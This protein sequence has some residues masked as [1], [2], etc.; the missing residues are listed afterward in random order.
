MLPKKRILVGAVGATVAL[1]LQTPVSAFIAK[2][3][4]RPTVSPASGQRPPSYLAEAFSDASQ[5][6]LGSDRW[7]GWRS[8]AGSALAGDSE[9]SA[10]TAAPV[11]ST[12]GDVDLA[13]LDSA[14]AASGRNSFASAAGAGGEGVAH[15]SYIGGS[16][17]GAGGA[18][19]VGGVG[20]GGG[21]GGSALSRDALAAQLLGSNTG[22]NL[23]TGA[24]LGPHAG[25]RTGVFHGVPG[26][27][28]ILDPANG[29]SVGS[30]NVESPEPG[31]L[32]FLGAGLAG[33]A[34]RRSRRRRSSGGDSALR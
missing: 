3:R 12:F 33:L 13:Y 20:G 19:G 30:A 21:G 25:Y 31:T 34:A 5:R 32:L 28:V 2:A 26:P 22:G 27:A 10:G 4:T 8:D 9:A 24:L 1:T 11:G 18:G 16:G 15:A 23:A 29:G 7:K 6:M 17:G 14:A